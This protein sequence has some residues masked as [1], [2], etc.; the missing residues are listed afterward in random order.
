MS[1]PLMWNRFT[2]LIF[3]S[4]L[5]LGT[6]F[7]FEWG[8]ITW[9]ISSA[10]EKSWYYLEVG[11]GH[12]KNLIPSQI[13]LLSFS[14]ANWIFNRNHSPVQTCDKIER[15]EILDAGNSIFS[16]APRYHRYVFPQEWRSQWPIH[17][18]PDQPF[19]VN[20]SPVLGRRA[21][22]KTGNSK[23]LIYESIE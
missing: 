13:I 4:L 21:R 7:V 5:F 14:A 16:R 12:S 18:A 8:V 1:S 6:V 17:L 23:L 20:E 10:N 2:S 19:F 9:V 11:E 3:F 15:S 22:N